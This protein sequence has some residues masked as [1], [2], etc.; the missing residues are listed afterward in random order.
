MKNDR[1]RRRLLASVAGTT[2]FSFAGCIGGI[3]GGGDNDSHDG[4]EEKTDGDHH[5]ATVP[6]G[7]SESATV[8]MKTEDGKSHFVPHIV[9]VHGGGTVTFETESGNHTATAYHPENDSPRR[10]P[11]D[12]PA[13]DSGIVTADDGPYER[14]FEATGIHDFYC[15]PHHA[16]GMVGT[17]I[18]GEPE[19]ADQPGLSEPQQELPDDARSKIETLNDAV[20]E[21]VDSLN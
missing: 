10:V 4:H 19:N 2:L 16:Q 21:G 5:G 17:V 3:G 6:D 1:T 20:L 13:W 15:E 12:A 11:E 18:V 8:T 9:W 7:P 14:T